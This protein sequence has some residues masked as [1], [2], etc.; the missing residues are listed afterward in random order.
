L[1]RP[2]SLAS[3]CLPRIGAVISGPIRKGL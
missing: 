2:K 1:N 3:A